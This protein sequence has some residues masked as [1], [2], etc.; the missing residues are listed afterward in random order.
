[1]KAITELRK[2]GWY[3]VIG[4]DGNTYTDDQGNMWFSAE[5]AMAIA[6]TLRVM[7]LR[8]SRGGLK[9]VV[10]GYVTGDPS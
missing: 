9:D 10:T 1:M 2:T 8:S 4:E 5:I 7:P 6:R 3:L